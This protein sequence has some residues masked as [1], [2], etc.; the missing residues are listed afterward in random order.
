[1]SPNEP[2]PILRPSR[3]L[4]P[5]RSS[6]GFSL[7]SSGLASRFLS[8]AFKVAL[9]AGFVYF[10]CVNFCFRLG[11][12]HRNDANCVLH[13]NPSF[14]SCYNIIKRFC[15]KVY[16]TLEGRVVLSCGRSCLKS[17]KQCFGRGIS[18]TKLSAG[19]Y[20]LKAVKTSIF[21]FKFSM[22]NWNWFLCD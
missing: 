4:F 14:Q 11:T 9:K 2:E 19:I 1:M 16:K 8:D 17:D 21:D 3:Y 5:T 18:S 13:K 6:I 10:T 7:S 22:R 15:E 20:V 12:S